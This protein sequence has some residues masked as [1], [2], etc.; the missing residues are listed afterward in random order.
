MTPSARISAAI[1]VI[2]DI[3]TNRRPASDALK[4]WGLA[5]RF[6]GSGDRA[7]IAGLVYDTLRRKSSA[8]Y[9]IGSD[10]PRAAVLG[11]L[12][13]ERGQGID[14]IKMLFSGQRFAPEPL[15]ESE[16]A[17]LTSARLEDAPLPI[18]GDYPEWLD[19]YLARTFGDDRALEAAALARRAPLD[20]RVNTL[21]GSRDEALTA[22]AHLGARPCRYSP[23]GLRIDLGAD[24]K[25]PAIQAEPAFLK[26][27]IEVQDE[28]SQ[29]VA[30]LT[31]ARPGETVIDLCAG[32]G[33]KTLALAAAMENRGRIFATDR[34]KRRLA[35]IHDRL[36]RAGVTCVDVRT[37]A[38]AT[39]PAGD[40]A[41]A[42]DLVLIDAPCTGT[43]TW[44]RNPD[45]KWRTRPGALE[46]RCK[47]QAEVLDRAAALVKPSGRIA[48]V[49]CSVLMEENDDQVKAFAARSSEF[50]IVPPHEIGGLPN[51]GADQLRQAARVSEAGLLMTPRRTETDG[52]FLAMLRK[53][54]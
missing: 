20:L 14:A 33:G 34:D 17:A 6:A 46:Q 19:P 16:N 7:A 5:H 27:L 4:A 44:R 2:G 41:N 47:E 18:A 37:P 11:M 24:A 26:G 12:K 50:Q 21:K 9:L 8:S 28:G 52:F 42:A 22:L 1:E 39:D 35:P 54:G 23:I 45:A 38:G 40:L 10:T 49:T 48:Y 15:E 29:L 31:G 30:Q 36:K 3:D 43:G 32:A 25:S 53:A 51:A 13:L